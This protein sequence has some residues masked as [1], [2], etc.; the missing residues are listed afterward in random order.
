MV[1]EPL[2]LSCHT[3]PNHV[4]SDKGDGD[5]E[6]LAQHLHVHLFQQTGAGQCA[7]QYSNHDGTSQARFDDA[8]LHVNHG[9]STGSDAHHEVRRGRA[10]FEGHFHH[11]IHRQDFQHAGAY[12]ENTAQ[13]AGDI[14]HAEASADVAQFVTF[15]RTVLFR[16]SAVEP[17]ASSHF[18]A[19]HAVVVALAALLHRGSQQKHAAVDD[20]DDVIVQIDGNR[21]ATDRADGSGDFEEHAETHVGHSLLDVGTAGTAGGRDAG[22]E[23][24]PDGVVEIHAEA[25]G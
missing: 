15:Q 11:G 9:G 19:F 8:A 1:K 4:E 7:E 2:I 23:C 16:E 21:G 22:D 3:L 13:H 14:H 10:H 20:G 18:R 5:A 25:E 6:D 24:R 17:E 12:A